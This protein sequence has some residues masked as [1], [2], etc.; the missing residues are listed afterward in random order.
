MPAIH[1][2]ERKQNW[3]CINP[4][5]NE[6]ESGYWVVSKKTA[7]QLIGGRIYLHG[8][9]NE[10]SFCGGTI[11]GYRNASS[12]PRSKRIIF[13]FTRDASH[14][15]LVTEKQGWGNEQKRVWD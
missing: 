12:E 10:P 2:I 14:E 1:L 15:G 6:W 5:L 3:K 4:E 11:T 13:T 9:Q 8:G 7:D